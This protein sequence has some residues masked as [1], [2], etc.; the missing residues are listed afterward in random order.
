MK[1]VMFTIFMTL[2]S[3]SLFAQTE[4]IFQADMG[5]QVYRGL[6]DPATDVL[7]AR[8]S[9]QTDAGDPGGDW[10]GTFFTLTDADNDTIY[11]VTA[12]LP[13]DSAGKAYFFK[14]VKN[15]EW[16][17]NPDRTFTLAASSPQELPVYWF[18]ND[19]S[20]VIVATVTNTINFTADL[21]GI[22]GVGAGGAFDPSQDSI[23]VL[24]FDW[25]GLGTNVEGNR[26]MVQDPFNPGLF[27]TTLSFEKTTSDSTK[28]KYRAFPGERF[29]DGGWE[30]GQDRWFFFQA[31][32]AVIDLPVIVPRIQP[33]FDAV[34]QDVSVTFRVDMSNAVNEY[35][36][37]QIDP[38]SIEFVGLR[39]GAD[40]LGNWG[41]GGWLPADTATG[42][43]KVLNDDGVNGDVS[44]GDNIWSIE[45]VVP[46]GTN[47]GVYQYK[48]GVMY[49]GADTVNGGTSPLDN[50]GGFGE[51]HILF[52][53]DVPSIVENKVFGDFTTSIRQ[54]DDLVPNQFDLSQN[55]PNP[56]NPSTK[57]VYS[58]P[59]EAVVTL[60]I[61]NLLGQEVTTLINESQMPGTYE[62]N[63]DASKLS[64]GIYFYTLSSKNLSLTK[65]MMLL[66]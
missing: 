33:L 6:F 60:K 66:K 50:E 9:F 2:L 35:N 41:S 20:Y 28:W 55:Y 11:T 65:K 44:A 13:A 4:V 57:I 19:S 62:A 25:D 45:I 31:D 14:F 15:E 10:Q 38:S 30:T 52:L 46:S 12:T 59:A 64:S 16:E 23:Q 32:G 29:A 42:L 26:T 54:I 49:P 21:S 7:V 39:G 8:G 5:S 22:L 48:F 18:N 43:M 61:F 24:G 40:F 37:E 51:N 63:F 58:V 1:K 27:T 34:T 36:D 53:E 47:G 56:F 3:F 17:S